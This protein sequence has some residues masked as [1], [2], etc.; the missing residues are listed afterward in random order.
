MKKFNTN[1]DVVFGDIN[2]SENRVRQIHGEEQNPGSGGWPTIRYFNKETGYGGK[3]YSKK[4]S[5][6]MCEELGDSSYMQ[7]YVEEMGKTSLCSVFKEGNPGCNE[8]ESKYITKMS[9]KTQAERQ[10]QL[11]RLST[12]KNKKMSP[13]AMD[14]I[15]ARI[16]ILKQF[17]KGTNTDEL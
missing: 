16:N 2:L 4:T 5:K 9:S 1:N 10:K 7:A 6:P 14:W 11:D 13:S 12:L 15:V 8:K 3:P 17:S